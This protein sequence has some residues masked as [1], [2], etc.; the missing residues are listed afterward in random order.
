MPLL[1]W[2][3]INFNIEHRHQGVTYYILIVWGILYIGAYLFLVLNYE[4]PKFHKLIFYLF[5]NLHFIIMAA[6]KLAYTPTNELL[7]FVRI[8]TIIF[9]GA[10]LILTILFRK[11]FIQN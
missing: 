3:I 5:I 10:G 11:K 8:F 1:A 9:F 7:F 2:E 6:C 4:K